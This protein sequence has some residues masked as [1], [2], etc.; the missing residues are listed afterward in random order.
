MATKRTTKTTRKTKAAQ[1]APKAKRPAS[2]PR[3]RTKKL[4]APEPAMK[5]RPAPAMALRPAQVRKIR[6]ARKKGTLVDTLAAEYGCSP[7]T[8][9]NAANARGAYASI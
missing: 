5:K 6:T 1:T 4:A 9:R 7:G 8:I 2:T 3:A